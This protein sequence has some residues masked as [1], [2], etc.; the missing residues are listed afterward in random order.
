VQL[1]LLSDKHNSGSRLTVD[2]LLQRWL[3]YGVVKAEEQGLVERLKL[4]FA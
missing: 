3:S 1:Q 2:A 4:V